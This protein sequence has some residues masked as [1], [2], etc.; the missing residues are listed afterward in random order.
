MDSKPVTYSRNDR[1]PLKHIV[2]RYLKYAGMTNDI[3]NQASAALSDH[4]NST[5]CPYQHLLLALQL[6]NVD[7]LSCLST[8]AATIIISC[9][10]TPEHLVSRVWFLLQSPKQETT[11]YY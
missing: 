7:L 6:N 4:Q 1:K 2:T 10:C 9:T 11:G 8:L 3:D 5:I